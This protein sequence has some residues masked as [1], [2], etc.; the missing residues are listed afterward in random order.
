MTNKDLLSGTGNSPQ[1]FVI[2]Y[3]GKETEKEYIYIYIYIYMNNFSVHLKFTD[4]HI[5]K[6]IYTYVSMYLNRFSVH[7]KLTHSKSTILKKK[8][9]FLLLIFTTP[10][11]FQ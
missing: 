1:Y 7:L 11:N 10:H 5:Y 4:I 6:K 8:V 2:T 3:K 9:R